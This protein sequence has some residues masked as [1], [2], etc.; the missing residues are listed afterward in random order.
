MFIRVSVTAVTLAL[1]ASTFALAQQAAVPQKV[2]Y[3]LAA[4]NNSG[5][6]GT[7]TITPTAD[8]KGS[9]VLVETKGQGALPQPVHVH[10]GPC[11][12]LVAT[13]TYPLKTLEAGKSETTLAAVPV[14]ELTNGQYAINV[15]KST[16]EGNVYV[17][18]V[19]LA[20][21]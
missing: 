18:C 7:I 11:A 13:P 3:N 15:H 12:L 17:A 21:K 20:K 2:T 16:T 8:G 14:T 4:Q 1:C 6:T 10:H 5:E 19:D 9:I